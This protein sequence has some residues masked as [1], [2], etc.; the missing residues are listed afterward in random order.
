MLEST[1]A[2]IRLA[3]GVVD[4][5]LL[6]LRAPNQGYVF[7]HQHKPKPTCMVHYTN[8]HNSIQ[9]TVY[10]ASQLTVFYC[11]YYSEK[12]PAVHR[13]LQENLIAVPSDAD[14]DVA[15]DETSLPAAAVAVGGML[16]AAESVD[17]AHVAVYQIVHIVLELMSHVLMMSYCGL[18]VVH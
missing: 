10:L 16:L 4:T 5:I 11:Y 8:N 9:L 17:S 14:P 1:T 7:L 12:P 15:V 2:L 13:I 3:Q 18:M 6:D